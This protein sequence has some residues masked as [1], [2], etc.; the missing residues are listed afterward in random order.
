MTNQ[1]RAAV[2]LP[3]ILTDL[4]RGPYPDYIDHV[5]AQTA[6]QRQWPAWASLGRWIPM[7]D[8]AREPV[9]APRIPVRPLVLAIVLIGLMLAGLAALA[10]STRTELPLP[11][12]RAETGLVAFEA[13]GDLFTA[14]VVTG[15][16]RAIVS[17]PETDLHP[18]FSL[19]GTRIAFARQVS[20]ALTEVYTV[21]ADGG[22]LRLVTPDPVMLAYPGI[23]REWELF[24]FS[25]DGTSVLISM[26]HDGRP[27]IAIAATDGSGIRVLDVGMDATEPSFRPPDGGEV[28]F[29]GRGR[30]IRDG[31][32]VA[33][34]GVFAVDVETGA[35]RSLVTLPPG[36]NLAGAS[37]SP[38][39]GQVAYWRWTEESGMTA[40]SHVVAADGTRSREIPAPKGALWNAHATWSN[41]GERLF[42]VH[43]FTSDFADV[44]GWVVPADLSSA[45][46]E[47]APAGWAETECC[48][49]W[50]WAPDDSMLLGRLVAVGDQ[51]A[52]QVLV[53]VA[54]REVREPAWDARSAPS[55]QRLASAP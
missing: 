35:V 49:A 23:G 44:R 47:V 43:G 15:A 17:G 8:V 40:R 37:W 46:V 39:G 4:A 54:T 28:L 45:G 11:Y 48:A 13:G 27:S 3:T 20:A 9:L 34:R 32:E 38:D 30:E 29:V 16:A 36:H 19:D 5:L 22:E 1:R 41:D 12:G 24:E 50:S 2:D 33:R 21:R 7:L 42:L 18:Q 52:R 6:R 55:W 14:D 26:V 53:D 10:G 25:P 51:P 31:V